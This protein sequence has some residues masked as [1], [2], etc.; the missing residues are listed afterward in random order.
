MNDDFAEMDLYD[1]EENGVE[2]IANEPR[3]PRRLVGMVTL[4]GG[5]MSGM[6]TRSTSDGTVR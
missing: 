5:I 3:R 2:V 4:C 1:I 6:I